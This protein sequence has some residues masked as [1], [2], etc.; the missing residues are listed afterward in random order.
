M[1]IRGLVAEGCLQLPFFD[2]EDLVEIQSSE[3]PEE[4]LMSCYK[5]LLAEERKRKREDLL[6]A[7]ER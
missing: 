5:R 2:E 1:A 7:T 3:Y 4:W 6:Q